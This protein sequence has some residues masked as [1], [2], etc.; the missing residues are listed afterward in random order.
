MRRALARGEGEGRFE[1]KSQAFH[2][3]LRAGYLA[4]AAAEPDR[5]RVL[6]ADR[7]V[8]AVAADVWREAALMLER[9]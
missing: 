4:I 8:E 2:E 6:D 9:A 5:C 7:T 3:R 1:S